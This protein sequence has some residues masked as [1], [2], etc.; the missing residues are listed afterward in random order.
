MTEIPKIRVPS[1]GG[2]DP[3]TEGRHL[4]VSG[5]TEKE[6]ELL[7]ASIEGGHQWVRRGKDGRLEH[8]PSFE[9]LPGPTTDDDMLPFWRHSVE[10]EARQQELFGF[11]PE[12]E[13]SNKHASPAIY[14]SSLCGYNYTAENYKRE[15]AKLTA[16]GFV[17]MRSP[18]DVNSGQYCEKWY[19]SGVWAVEG[20]LKKALFRCKAGTEN[21]KFKF[22]LD[23]LRRNASF[24]SLNVV[25]QRF[26]MVL[27]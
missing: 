24:G 14:I 13:A 17:C 20:Q 4:S 16:Y 8:V 5:L 7:R 18:R 27:D 21:E 12:T 23:Y 6:S 9:E 2:G 15:A 22:V 3:V 25:V 19:L 10:G 1:Y 11:D 26:A